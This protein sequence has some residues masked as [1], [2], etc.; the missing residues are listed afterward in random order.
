MSEALVQTERAA[1]RIRS[2]LL[3]T[4]KELDRRRQRAFDPGHQLRAHWPALVAGAAGVLTLV[5]VA[6]TVGTVRDRSRRTALNRARFKSVLRAWEHPERVASSD[7]D[8]RLPTDMFRKVAL[9]LAGALAHRLAQRS[10]K[11][12]IPVDR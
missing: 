4:L 3:S 9:T 8:R 6:M 10:A 11:R 2:E 1:D 7:K 12:L 5:A